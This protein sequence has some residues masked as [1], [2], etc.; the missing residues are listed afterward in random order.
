[1]ER[2]GWFAKS[3]I[4]TFVLV[5]VPF[6]LGACGPRVVSGN[7]NAVVVKNGPW[8]PL[9]KAETSAKSYCENYSKLA[10]YEGGYVK[11]GTLW[12]IYHFD[13]VDNPQ[14]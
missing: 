5:I 4:G 8:Y 11:R 6:A 14:T 9:I 13:C 1:M 3:V 7:E 12:Y 10:S 2:I